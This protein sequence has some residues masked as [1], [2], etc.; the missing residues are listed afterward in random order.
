MGSK[1]DEAGMHLKVGEIPGG[2]FWMR[3][4][5]KRAAGGGVWYH[6][7]F[8]WGEVTQTTT[9]V[10]TEEDPEEGGGATGGGAGGVQREMVGPAVVR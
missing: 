9:I 8:G 10:G 2:T 5:V 3:P 1:R 7:E 4:W 6:R